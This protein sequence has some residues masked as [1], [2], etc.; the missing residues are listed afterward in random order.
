MDKM[1][2]RDHLIL[3]SH[4]ND[5][6]TYKII[7]SNSDEKVI[8]N[9]RKH[10][11]KYRS[12]LTDKEYNYLSKYERQSSNF[13][14]LP[15][16]H[17]SKN[18]IESIKQSN[19]DYIEI[20][21][22]NDLKG[23]PIIAGCSAPTQRLSSFIEKLLTPITKELKTYI[24]DDW[25]FLRQIPQVLNYNNTILFSIDI[26]SLYTSISHELGITAIKYWITKHRDL[27][28]ERFTIEFIMESLKFVLNNNNFIFDGQMRH[29][30][31]GTSMGT[32]L[33]PPYACLSIGYLEETVLF[34][35]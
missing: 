2:Y 30:E 8:E 11:E 20:E 5:S 17:K 25:H 21:P 33:A 22:P 10:V 28:P 12:C 24:K 13:Y 31:T 3:N 23:R 1:Y 27:I 14:V 4:L 29:Q 15:K 7:E 6:E 26:V 32:K 9:H 16:I 35:E 18:I 19:S 34:P